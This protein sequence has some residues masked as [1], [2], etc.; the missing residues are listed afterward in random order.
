MEALVLVSSRHVLH[1]QLNGTAGVLLYQ[2][3]LVQAPDASPGL[4]SQLPAKNFCSQPE[5]ETWKLEGGFL[6]ALRK[7]RTA[8]PAGS[9]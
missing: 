3:A 9:S 7:L 6:P 5:L 2:Q 4:R 1:S 8:A